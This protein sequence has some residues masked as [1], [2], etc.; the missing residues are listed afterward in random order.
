MNNFCL[1]R[2]IQG[3]GGKFLIAY[4]HSLFLPSEQE[5]HFNQ[6]QVFSYAD[7]YVMNY[8][9][10][11]LAE[12][13]YSDHKF[14]DFSRT[15][16]LSN[17]E[18]IKN[19]K[20]LLDDLKNKFK[21]TSPPQ[22]NFCYLAESHVVYY[23]EIFG[24]INNL[25]IINIVL[26]PKDRIQA[27]T[28]QIKKLKLL[29]NISN[30]EIYYNYYQKQISKISEKEL[31]DIINEK[32]EVVYQKYSNYNSPNIP[33]I[34]INFKDIFNGSLEKLNEDLCNFMGVKFDQYKWE[35]FTKPLY[36]KY[37][38]AQSLL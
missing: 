35:T 26:D 22:S 18:Y 30:E 16:N 11:N 13:L 10:H 32:I 29:N 14:K 25:K 38:A 8:Y 33:K 4:L 23:E 20:H 34:D 24:W 1:I 3:S 5:E 37:L 19:N 31:I 17:Y 12:L 15:I 36:Q 2:Y 28:K 27:I 6:Q 7:N 9:Y 21:L